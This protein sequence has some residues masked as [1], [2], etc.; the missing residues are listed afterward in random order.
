MN[1]GQQQP[2]YGYPNPNTNQS[3]SYPQQSMNY[4]NNMNNGQQPTQQQSQSSGFGNIGGSIG[5]MDMN[6][7]Q[8]LGNIAATASKGTFDRVMGQVTPGAQTTWTA[9]RTLFAVSSKSTM[10]KI[11]R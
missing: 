5:G 4:N 8:M 1:Y 9:L 10:S 11:Q 7:A 2:Q 3:Q 6:Q